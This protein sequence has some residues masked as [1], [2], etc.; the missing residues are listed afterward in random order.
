MKKSILN[1]RSAN[2]G[3]VSYVLVLTTAAI[4]TMLMVATYRQAVNSQAVQRNVQLRLD[5]GEKEDTILRSI[6]SMVPNRAI[7]AMQDSSLTN[8]ATLKLSWQDI[9]TDALVAANARTSIPSS[10]VTALNISNLRQGNSGD[11]ALSTP[12]MIFKAISPEKPSLRRA[13]TVTGMFAL[14]R[15]LRLDGT[16]R[17]A[18]SGRG[19]LIRKR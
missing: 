12:S 18:K 14:P 5:Y 17:K 9:F 4:L 6:V 3:Y 2:P 15:A 1:R 8:A 13:W 19:E 7:L 11:S 10:V 16:I